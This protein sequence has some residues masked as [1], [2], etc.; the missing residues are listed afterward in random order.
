MWQFDIF[1]IKMGKQGIV[2]DV[3]ISNQLPVHASSWTMLISE[4]WSS[5]SN[6]LAHE[7]FSYQAYLI[8]NIM[9][10]HHGLL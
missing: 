1:K 3:S 9:N 5:V 4:W 2:F 10:I 6:M 7:G 8:L